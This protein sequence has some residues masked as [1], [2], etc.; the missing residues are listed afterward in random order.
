MLRLLKL[1]DGCLAR[2]VAT[3]AFEAVISVQTRPVIA[4][5]CE[6]GVLGGLCVETGLGKTDSDRLI[7]KVKLNILVS[8][9]LINDS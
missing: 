3:D 6:D 5:I 8:K 2:E 9:C 4:D 7:F 1:L